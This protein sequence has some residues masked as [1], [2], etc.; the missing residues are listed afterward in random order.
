MRSEGNI[1]RFEFAE[2]VG[3]AR[4]SGSNASVTVVE[5][6]VQ[7]L[8]VRTPTLPPSLQDAPPKPVLSK[9]QALKAYKQHF[10]NYVWAK[11][12]PGVLDFL[13]I[14]LVFDAEGNRLVWETE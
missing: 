12:N 14:D 13:V 6:R 3:E 8:L 9:E 5:G 2:Y 4:V 7:V 1:R 11:R 10:G